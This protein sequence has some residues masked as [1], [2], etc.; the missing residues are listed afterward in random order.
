[1]DRL[2]A[3]GFGPAF[4]ALVVLAALIALEAIAP[5]FGLGAALRL[6]GVAR[7]LLLTLLFVGLTLAF[8]AVSALQPAWPD[9]LGGRFYAEPPGFEA[10]LGFA[11]GQIL[12]AVLFDVLEI[13][14]IAVFPLDYAVS[15]DRLHPFCG[16]LVGFKALFSIGFVAILARLL[17][18][19]TRPAEARARRPLLAV[20]F[21]TFSA[22]A[23][24]FGV[25]TVGVMVG[26]VMQERYG[27]FSL[28]AAAMG[29]ALGA[30][31][32]LRS[33]IRL[34]RLVRAR[35]EAPALSRGHAI[36]LP[37][38]LSMGF[39]L[40]FTSAA[41]LGFDDW[42]TGEAG[43]IRSPLVGGN[44]DPAA[45]VAFLQVGNVVLFDALSTCL[46][47]SVGLAHYSPLGAALF[48]AFRLTLSFCLIAIF[49][50]VAGEVA[51]RL[52][53]NRSAVDT[54]RERWRAR[55]LILMIVFFSAA[56]PVWFLLAG[57]IDAGFRM[58]IP[59]GGGP[60]LI[61]DKQGVVWITI[62]IGAVFSAIAF[63]DLRV[64]RRGVL[65]LF[66]D[67]LGDRSTIGLVASGLGTLAIALAYLSFGLFLSPV[68]ALLYFGRWMDLV[69]RDDA[70][71]RSGR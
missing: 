60:P 31:I 10:A 32:F 5:R 62:A 39:V 17:A 21:V 68:F 26:V 1:M 50:K 33:V 54:P 12:E 19:R 69:A 29:L 15:D 23:T 24:V 58:E 46:P 9:W 49:A 44:V 64:L 28:I 37:L 40:L 65:V 16:A 18:A 11:F 47:R 34:I 3:A 4:G 57:G 56:L 63:L 67:S 43:P 7:D 42:L 66:S 55:R 20:V 71:A 53:E 13:F 6:R 52:A 22:V 36:A 27:V 38:L 59:L 61:L 30:P 48:V 2:E 70:V 25:M 51:A 14:E 45:G 41:R 35:E 8:A